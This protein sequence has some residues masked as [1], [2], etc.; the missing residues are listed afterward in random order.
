MSNN[1]TNQPTKI[2]GNTYKVTSIL[3]DDEYLQRRE[4]QIFLRKFNE[5]FVKYKNILTEKL[6]ELRQ[7]RLKDLINT[8][9]PVADNSCIDLDNKIYIYNNWALILGL[10][11]IIVAVI[12]FFASYSNNQ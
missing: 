3:S 12:L 11:F 7:K 5:D 4:Q 1:K 2:I 6:T 8:E 9:K 10:I